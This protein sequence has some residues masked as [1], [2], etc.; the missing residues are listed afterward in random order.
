VLNQYLRNYVGA[1]Q[2]DWGEHLALAEFCYNSITHLTTKM[3]SFELALGKEAQKS[4]DLTIPVGHRDH[5]KKV[6]EMVKGHE[7]K[8]TQAKNFWSKFKNNMRSMPTKH[9]G[10]LNLKLGNTCG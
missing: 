4:M 8:Y 2:K 5:S 10:M 7:D 9:K 1:D 6:V 3:S